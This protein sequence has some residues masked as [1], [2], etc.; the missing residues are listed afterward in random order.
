MVTGAGS[1]LGRAM[2]IALANSGAKVAGVDV[3]T[4]WKDRYS[5]DELAVRTALFCEPI[6]GA[7]K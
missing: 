7:E 5:N 3:H 2:A 6:N 1:G 4:H